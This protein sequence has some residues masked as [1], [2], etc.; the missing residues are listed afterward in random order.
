MTRTP[1]LPDR[2]GPNTADV[3]V[4]LDTIRALT[5]ETAHRLAAASY[6]PW[7]ARWSVA[8]DAAAATGRAD[9]HR[10]ATFDAMRT[11][12]AHAASRHSMWEDARWAARDA[13]AALVVADLVGAHGLE[14]HDLDTLLAPWR[15]IVDDDR[16]SQLFLAVAGPGDDAADVWAAVDAALA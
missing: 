7:K 12:S 4:V 10:R 5:A 6:H 11:P 3:Q 2:Y 8:R 13:V 1:A 9:A 16:R 14:Q 15:A